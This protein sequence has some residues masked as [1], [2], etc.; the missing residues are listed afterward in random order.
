M[1]HY[2]KKV[3]GMGTLF[4]IGSIARSKFYLSLERRPTYMNF[5]MRGPTYNGTITGLVISFNGWVL[6]SHIRS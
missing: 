6:L 2:A 4:S 3:F 1:N 5:I